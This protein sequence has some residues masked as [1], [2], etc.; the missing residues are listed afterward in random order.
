MTIQDENHPLEAARTHGLK[1]VTIHGS[2]VHPA[3]ARLVTV[4]RQFALRQ[5]LSSRSCQ[6]PPGKR[7]VT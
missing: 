6:N 5:T 2:A 3:R 1:R 7:L 4:V